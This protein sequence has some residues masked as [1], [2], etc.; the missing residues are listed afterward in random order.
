MQLIELAFSLSFIKAD[1]D[2]IGIG[3]GIDGIGIGIDGIGIDGIGIDGIG[4]DGIGIV[5][6]LSFIKAG[7]G[8][9]VGPLAS[10]APSVPWHRSRRRSRHRSRRSL[11]LFRHRS[12]RSRRRSRRRSVASVGRVGRAVGPRSIE[13]EPDSPYIS[14]T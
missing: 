14:M 9:D 8:R 3:I 13:I 6:S 10:V 4:I 2:G 5:F 7:P 11:V 1:I 12:H